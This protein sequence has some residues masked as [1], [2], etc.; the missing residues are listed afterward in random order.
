MLN[1]TVHLARPSRFLLGLAHAC[2]RAPLRSL[3]ALTGTGARPARL[4]PN[5]NA[6]HSVR[7]TAGWDT[8]GAPPT[9]QGQAPRSPSRHVAPHGRTPPPSPLLFPS[10]SCR[11]PSSLKNTADPPLV[12]SLVTDPAPA[13]LSSTTSLPTIFAPVPSPRT[14]GDLSLASDFAEHRRC[15]PPLR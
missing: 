2:P 6:A 11:R 8:V 10:Q 5:S 13:P 14:T 1:V 3:P 4:Y 15:L 12:H 9:G 7:V